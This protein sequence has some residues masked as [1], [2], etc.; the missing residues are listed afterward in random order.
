MMTAKEA[1]ANAIARTELGDYG[2][3]QIWL[4]IARELR[5][6][7][8]PARDVGALRVGG[9]MFTPIEHIAGY[10][11]GQVPFPSESAIGFARARAAAIV[12]GVSASDAERS[13]LDEILRRAEENAPLPD[14]WLAN[15]TPI[16]E[17][18]GETLGDTQ[19]MT[20][21]TYAAEAVPGAL[22][23]TYAAD[24]APTETIPVGVAHPEPGAVGE[25]GVC[26]NCTF[27][28]V[29]FRGQGW[30]H[31]RDDYPAACGDTLA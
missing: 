23:T 10:I 5:L 18:A 11:R 24:E 1:M 6:G 22:E 25:D 4:G 9:D 14:R 19:I 15:T 12:A 2:G 27:P 3:G 13:L 8:V 26:L 20:P 29:W 16:Y 30:R 7:S 31:N 21:P 28:I 17:T